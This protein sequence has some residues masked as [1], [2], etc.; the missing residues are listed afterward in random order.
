MCIS[1]LHSTLVP[2]TRGNVVYSP[3]FKAE[4]QVWAMR[5]H[6]RQGWRFTDSIIYQCSCSYQL[7]HQMTTCHVGGRTNEKRL[8]KK[9][10]TCIYN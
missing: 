8:D 3:G 4:R 7:R 5:F 10:L 1:L 2:D 9:G 6:C